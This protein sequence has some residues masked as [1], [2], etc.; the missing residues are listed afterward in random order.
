MFVGWLVGWFGLLVD[1]VYCLVN[2]VFLGSCWIDCYGWVLVVGWS[3]VLS[4]F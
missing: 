4:G 1:F 3:W 2:V